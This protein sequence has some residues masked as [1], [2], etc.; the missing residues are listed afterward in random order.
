[1]TQTTGMTGR[2]AFPTGGR[3]VSQAPGWSSPGPGPWATRRSRTWPWPGRA[4]GKPDPAPAHDLP[5]PRGR[6]GLQPGSGRR[7]RPPWRPVPASRFPRRPRLPRLPLGRP[8]H[9]PGARRSHPR[10][11]G[12]PVDHRGHLDPRGPSARPAASRQ[13]DR[14]LVSHPSFSGHGR[15]RALR[16]RCRPAPRL[17]RP[18]LAGGLFGQPRP[19]RGPRG[20]RFSMEQDRR[21][22]RMP[23]SRG[24]GPTRAEWRRP[25]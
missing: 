13:T 2:R 22:F 4:R 15:F 19:G 10:Q 14:R 3:T 25:R 16:P 17:L 1:M 18:P 24:G 21:T 6:H 9:P 20:A 23:L 11:R 8:S 12:Q 5:P 7:R